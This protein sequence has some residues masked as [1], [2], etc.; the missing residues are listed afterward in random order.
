MAIDFRLTGTKEDKYETV[1]NN[2]RVRSAAGA[3]GTGK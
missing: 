2:I 3:Y 1:H